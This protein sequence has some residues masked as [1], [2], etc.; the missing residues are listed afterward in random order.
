[1]ITEGDLKACL[2]DVT[3]TMT[4]KGLGASV[5]VY[6]DEWGIPHIQASTE[7][8]LYYAQGFVTA[9][10]RLWHM[11]ADRFRAL[12]RWAECVGE[13][14]IDQDRLMRSAG[15]GR[16]AKLDYEVSSDASKAMLDAYVDGVNAFIATTEM[17]PIEYKLLGTQPEQWEA[18]HCITVYKMRNSLLG[19]FEPKL[20]RTK[21]AQDPE[22]V[23]ALAKI[24]TGYPEGHL[25][26]V[27]PDAEW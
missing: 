23:E 6:R 22:A 19:T 1:M 14:A 25:V 9:Q 12:G 3:S 4:L 11:D 7:R 26:T 24:L 13:S 27:P 21:M 5:D 2:P 10:D 15:M 16:T 20:L 8:D 18:W 17:L